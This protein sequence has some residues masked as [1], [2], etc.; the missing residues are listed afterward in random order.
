MVGIVLSVPGESNS[1]TRVCPNSS[2]KCNVT[3]NHPEHGKITVESEKG[4]NDDSVILP[5]IE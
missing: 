3:V 1:Q 2:I 4:P 5:E